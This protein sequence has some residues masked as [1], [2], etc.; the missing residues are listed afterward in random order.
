MSN[1]KAFSNEVNNQQG[2]GRRPP[3]LAPTKKFSMKPIMT[4]VNAGAVLFLFYQY[5]MR[6]VI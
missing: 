6:G 1:E 4:L 5:D 3:D 2:T